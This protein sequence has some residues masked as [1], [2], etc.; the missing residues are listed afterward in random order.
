MSD[1]TMPEAEFRE[2]FKEGIAFLDGLSARGLIGIAAPLGSL[3][4]DA[5]VGALSA[6][7]TEVEMIRDRHNG[8]HALHRD[9]L[10]LMKLYRN[11]CAARGLWSDV[12]QKEFDKLLAEARA[13][14]ATGFRPR[15]CPNMDISR[16]AK[17]GE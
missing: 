10:P 6:A 12:A 17:N 16:R 13:I 8:V 9:I 14:D 3:S 5:I 15:S 11:G 1:H 2:K 4:C 7:I